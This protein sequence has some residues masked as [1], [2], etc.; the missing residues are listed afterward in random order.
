M[1]RSLKLIGIV[2][3][4]ALA[5]FASAHSFNASQVSSLVP[6]PGTLV[7]LILAGSAL[8]RNRLAR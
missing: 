2:A 7:G 3:L 4:L 1:E 5:G 6:E 8:L